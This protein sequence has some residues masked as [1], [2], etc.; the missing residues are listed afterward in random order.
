[1]KNEGGSHAMDEFS[2]RVQWREFGFGTHSLQLCVP[3]E[4]FIRQWYNRQKQAGF[5]LSF[6][7]WAK[8][9]PAAI[10]LCH[11][12]EMRPSLLRDAFV[13]ELAAGLGLPSVFAASH[14]REVLCTDK[15]VFAV[16]MV[17]A[18][19]KQNGLSNV[20]TAVLDW[21]QLPDG[22]E[23]DVL[24]LSDIN[25]EPAVF[26]ALYK[27][28]LHF[29]DLGTRVIISTPQRLMAGPF[30]LKLLPFAEE[31]RSTTVFEGD[32]P[33]ELTI[34]VLISQPSNSSFI[35]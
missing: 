33:V 12:L 34:L 21:N 22:L 31:Q 30:V 4:A 16:E 20:R 25:Y 5:A 7:Y 11:F 8:V 35:G 24:L 28:I 6:P 15:E 26:D 17:N 19:V 32:S 18:S 13:L 10:A 2:G 1:M 14:S 29:L 9:W 3:E 23:P 27:M